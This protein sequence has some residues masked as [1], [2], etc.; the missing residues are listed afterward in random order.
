M[1]VSFIPA[2]LRSSVD[3]FLACSK[4]PL[5]KQLINSHTLAAD[6]RTSLMAKIFSDRGEVEMVMQ[7]S[8]A[9]AQAFVDAVAWVSP[10]QRS[11]LWFRYKPHN[12]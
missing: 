11:N 5:W 7:L 3:R 8:G 2:I 4:H 6:E 12:L 9:D 1:S 10:A